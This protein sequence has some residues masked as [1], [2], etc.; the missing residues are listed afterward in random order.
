MRRDPRPYLHD[1]VQGADAI[2]ETVDGKSLDQY[3]NDPVLRAAVERHFI[4][5]GE[6]LYQLRRHFPDVARKIPDAR[7]LI[8]F[9]HVLVHGY[10]Q[11]DDE[12]AWGVIETMI[13]RARDAA[14][15]R[16]QQTGV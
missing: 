9:R 14:A 12:V 10:N 13:Q 5:V 3:L 6:A 8:G 11:V 16:L 1:I 2:L 15:A 7:H 4:V